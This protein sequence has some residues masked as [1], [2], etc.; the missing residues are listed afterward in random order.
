MYTKFWRTVSHQQRVAY[1]LCV[2][3]FGS[4]K[5][6]YK[7]RAPWWAAHCFAVKWLFLGKQYYKGS[8]ASRSRIIY[9]FWE[10]YEAEQKRKAS[11]CGKYV[12]TIRMDLSPLDSKRPN[13]AGVGSLEKWYLTRRAALIFVAGRLALAGAV[14]VLVKWELTNFCQSINCLLSLPL[15]LLPSHTL[16][17]IA[18]VL[19]CF[20]LVCLFATLWTV[21][22]Q[23]PMSMGFSRQ[24]YWSGW[25]C[26]L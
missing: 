23:A 2:L 15:W 14:S 3:Q 19:S 1:E 20:S 9:N 11:S 5:V 25:P 21:V 12:S 24:G 22:F 8:N 17:A 7:Q 13:Q 18:G 10:C 4:Y 6:W 16:Y 26:P